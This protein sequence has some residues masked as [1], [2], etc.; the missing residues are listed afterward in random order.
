MY[1]HVL[2]LKVTASEVVETALA[3]L[4]DELCDGVPVK[5]PNPD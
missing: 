2:E 3:K 4:K 1:K 5:L